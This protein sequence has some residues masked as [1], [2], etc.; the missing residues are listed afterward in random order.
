MAGADNDSQGLRENFT[1]IADALNSVNSDVN[2]LQINSVRTD[3]TTDFGNNIITN[4]QLLNCSETIYD[5]T[6]VVETGSITLDYKQG[7]YQKFKLGSGV[8]SINVINWPVAGQTGRLTLAVSS[9]TDYATSIDFTD[10]LTINL[11]SESLPFDLIEPHTYLFQLTHDGV[12]GR[13]YVKRANDIQLRASTLDVNSENV[14][15]TNVT[16]LETLSIG[17]NTYHVS[18]DLYT[19]VTARYIPQQIS[20]DI[21]IVSAGSK[22]SQGSVAVVT[23]PDYDFGVRAVAQITIDAPG[24]G[25]ITA[26]SLQDPGTGYSNTATVLIFTATSTSTV[27]DGT[28]GSNI[29][30]VAST[31]GIYVGMTVTGSTGLGMLNAPLVTAIGTGQVTVSSP[32]DGPVSSATLTF[33]DLG[34][35]FTAATTLVASTTTSIPVSGHVALL[36]HQVK[37]VVDAVPGNVIEPVYTTS[38]TV[39]NSDSIIPG[40]R[41]SFKGTDT[42]FVVASVDSGLITATESFLAG[43]GIVSHNDAII[44]TNPQFPGQPTFMSLMPSSISTIQAVMGDVKGQVYADDASAFITYADYVQNTNNKVQLA[45]TQSVAASVATLEGEI[46]A[47]AA[48]VAALPTIQGTAN[49]ITVVTTASTTTISISTASNGYGV[50]YISTLTPSGGSN[51]DIWYQI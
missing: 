21:T 13:T 48:N 18:K 11:N 15:G 19:V 46:Q 38:F 44:F 17:T 42:V 49:Q 8:H 5:G 16:A 22:Y 50:R 37:T 2:D 40:A 1:N 31:S 6:G 32:N 10:P 23:D 35:G 33:A 4:A 47:V 39:L 9:A 36:P 29:L 3:Q 25:G 41:F 43:T 30:T 34:T 12:D 24:T 26:I 27:A 45:T 20:P 51:G 28:S 7:S 14:T